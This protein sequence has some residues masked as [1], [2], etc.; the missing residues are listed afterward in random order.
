MIGLV[1]T[2]DE[3]KMQEKI[4]KPRDE[5][6]IRERKKVVRISLRGTDAEIH[7]TYSTFG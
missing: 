5:K 2:R 7:D 3:K 6:K 1:K 4:V